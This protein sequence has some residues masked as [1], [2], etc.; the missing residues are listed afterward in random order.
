MRIV[1]RELRS[2]AELLQGYL[3]GE[4]RCFAELVKRLEPEMLRYADSYLHNMADSRDI[5][6]DVFEEFIVMLA[7][8][9]YTEQG[10]LHRLLI[11]MVHH[12][13]EMYFREKRKHDSV[14]TPLDTAEGDDYD[15]A[16][17]QRRHEF[18]AEEMK[19]FR[20][21][22]H[23]LKPRA[24]R[25][26]VMRYHGRHSFED[27]AQRCNV[28]TNTATKIFSRVMEWLRK[29]IRENYEL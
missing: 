21:L 25:I 5:V 6:Q 15:R 23:E 7:S 27:I 3:N 2:D 13:V 19:I 17:E 26:V 24:K 10:K 4:Q 29:R 18:S 11:M 20:E 9:K 22:V 28:S 14:F 16:E 1:R 12:H 8:G